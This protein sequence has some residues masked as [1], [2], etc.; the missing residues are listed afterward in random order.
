MKHKLCFSLAISISFLW[1]WAFNAE[2]QPTFGWPVQ[3]AYNYLTATFG[4]PRP[5]TIPLG[6]LL[7]SG[8]VHIQGEVRVLRGGFLRIYSCPEEPRSSTTGRRAPC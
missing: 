3:S 5:N 1:A 2:A 6:P 7:C 4:E 8:K